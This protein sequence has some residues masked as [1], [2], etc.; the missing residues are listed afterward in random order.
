MLGNYSPSLRNLIAGA[1]RFDR[2]NEVVSGDI[3]LGVAFKISK[4]V[5]DLEVGG[6]KPDPVRPG[7]GDYFKRCTSPSFSRFWMH[8]SSS[9]LLASS[10]I[11]FKRDMMS[12]APRWPSQS[13][14]TM[15]AVLFK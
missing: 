5:E 2:N 1:E 10:N 11:F 3:N 9:T 14:K 15:A 8:A 12:S 13:S 4:A 7:A 6:A